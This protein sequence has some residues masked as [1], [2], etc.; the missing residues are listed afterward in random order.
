MSI[1][2]LSVKTFKIKSNQNDAQNHFYLIKS[3][4]V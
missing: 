3:L 1:I 2:R 4:K